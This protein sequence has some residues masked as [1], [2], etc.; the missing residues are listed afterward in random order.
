MAIEQ[1]Y[2]Q[3]NTSIIQDE[4]LSHRLGLIPINADPNLFEDLAAGDDATDLNTL[5]FKLDVECTNASAEASGAGP[6]TAGST[7]TETVYSRQLV[8]EPQGNQAQRFP[9]GIAPVHGDIIIALLRPGQN[10]QLEAHCVKG[11]GRDHTKFSPVA[12]ASYRILPDIRFL[13]RVTGERATELKSMCP[14]NVFDIEDIR[15]KPTAVA[16]RPRDCTMCRECIRT[17]DW[18]EYVEL[19][20]TADHFIFKVES[21]GA[22]PPQEIVREVS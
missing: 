14:L 5:V 17:G 10:I 8:W 20:R 13:K 16:A 3:S 15:G 21:V 1:I 22:I 19:R 18:N 11:I 4:V 7:P 6:H 12:T 9:D 2:I